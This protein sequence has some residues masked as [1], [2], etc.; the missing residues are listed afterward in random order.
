MIRRFNYTG[1]RKLSQSC[2][3]V[4]LF[5]NKD[6]PS[7]FQ[8]E[9]KLDNQSLPLKAKVYLEAYYRSSMMRFDFGTV[10][11]VHQFANE[12]YTLTDIQNSIAFFRVK[13]VDETSDIGRIIA[14]IDRI[15]PSFPQESDASKF[16]LLYVQYVDLGHQIWRVDISDNH[17]MPVLQVNSELTLDSVQEFIRNHPAFLSL[18][19]PAAV[20]E[21]LN[22]ILLSGELPEEQDESWQIQWLQFATSIKGERKITDFYLMQSDDR[23]I[24]IEEAVEA[25][26]VHND[27]KAKLEQGIGAE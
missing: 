25:F 20:R 27:L 17:A 23:Q 22:H 15:K 19:Y 2:A 5:Q 14:V 11:Q 7:E 26:C 18:V 16:S 21:I 3:S 24:W 8:A 13:I 4:H 10:A 12:R 1:R 6:A 9:L